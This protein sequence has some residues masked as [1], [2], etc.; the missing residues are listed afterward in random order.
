MGLSAASAETLMQRIA[1]RIHSVMARY[2][3]VKFFVV[4]KVDPGSLL[5]GPYTG[6]FSPVSRISFGQGL[7]GAA[8]AS[9]NTVVVN[10]VAADPR[11]L[12]ASELVKSEIVVPIFA[13]G[14]LAAEISVGS[15]FADTFGDVDRNFVEACGGVVGK[16]LE[17]HPVA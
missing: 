6:S 17:E 1:D 10:N 4:D 3:C 15:Y 16:Y 2:N 14:T 11:Y 8:A 9:G 12:S 13:R 5:L 7:V